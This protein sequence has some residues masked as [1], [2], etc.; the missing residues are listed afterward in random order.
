MGGLRVCYKIVCGVR[1]GG[2]G[3]AGAGGATVPGVWL[4]A[5]RCGACHG[6]GG[7]AACRAH[8]G[9]A[10][11]EQTAPAD[12][13]DSEH[14]GRT[15]V[16]RSAQSANQV[17][18]QTLRPILVQGDGD[19]RGDRGRVASLLARPPRAPG[20]RGRPGA[21]NQSA[22]AGGDAGG[23]RTAAVEEGLPVHG[24]T[25]APRTVHPARC[26]RGRSSAAPCGT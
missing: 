24:E 6:W 8:L 1:S 21:T 26:R 13:A 7:P 19:G 9:P 15:A 14:A 3:G 23:P 11:P 17:H 12:R 5:S 25:S 4:P 10:G 20:A 18:R 2:P 16:D 22:F